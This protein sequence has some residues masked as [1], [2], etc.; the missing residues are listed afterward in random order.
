MLRARSSTIVPSGS[1]AGDVGDEIARLEER[2]CGG[3]SNIVL[4][5]CVAAKAQAEANASPKAK[6][7][8]AAFKTEAKAKP[9]A[10]D[11]ATA[12]AA[13]PKAKGKAAPMILGCG[14]CRGAKKGC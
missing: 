2:E 12:K 10:K 13:T 7:V 4:E 1:P 9:E 8:A 5:A 3:D 14:K 11:K 6:A